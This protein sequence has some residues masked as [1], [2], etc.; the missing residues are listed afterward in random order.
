MRLLP[1]L[2][3]ALFVSACTSFKVAPVDEKTGYFPTNTKA[4]VVLSKPVDLDPRK[5]LLLIPNGEFVKGQIANIKYFDETMTFEDLERRIIQAGLTEKVP[6]VHERIGVN[7]AAKNYKP[8]LWLRFER[9]GEGRIKTGR[10][11]LTDPLTMEDWF[12][13][14]TKLDY[15]FAGVNDQNNWYPMFNSLID[16]IQQNSKTYRK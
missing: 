7:N 9:T 12:I 2:V 8:F 16:Y 5:G 14:E 10:F 4:T 11:V 15:A 1:A 3:L 13:A 6:S